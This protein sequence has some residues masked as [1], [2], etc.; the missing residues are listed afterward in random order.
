MIFLISQTL[1]NYLT[2]QKSFLGKNKHDL[3]FINSNIK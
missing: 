2:L 3:Y 1:I